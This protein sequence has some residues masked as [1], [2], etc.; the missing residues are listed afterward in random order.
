MQ[1]KDIL[2]NALLKYDGAL[3]IVSHDRDFLQGLTSKVF[4]FK[5]HNIRQYIGDIYNFLDSRKLESLKELELFKKNKNLLRS[6]EESSDN[7]LNW[8]RKKE[9]EK[10]GRRLNSQISKAE[11]EIIVLEKEIVIIDEI[12]ANPE[13]HIEIDYNTVY[14]K[15]GVLKQKLSETVNKWEELNLKMEDYKSEN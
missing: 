1:S 14:G 8:E 3:I 10:E 15:Y 6:G 4:E 12:L 7:K 5:N 11:E 2:K 9:R 13:K